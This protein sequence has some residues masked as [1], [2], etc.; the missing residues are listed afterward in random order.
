MR[1]VV[2]DGGVGDDL[3]DDGDLAALG[4]KVGEEEVGAWARRVSP[5]WRPGWPPT[6]RRRRR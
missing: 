4:G 6:R 2:L 1:E 5:S 3:G